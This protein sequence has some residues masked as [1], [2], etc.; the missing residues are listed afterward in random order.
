MRVFSVGIIAVLLL[1]TLAAGVI[2]ADTRMGG[3]VTVGPDE[4]VDDDLTVVGGTVVIEG[5]VTGDVTVIG[6]T[7]EIPGEV[8]GDVSIVGGSLQVAGV[9]AGDVS[10]AAGSVTI[11]QGAVIGSLAAGAGSVDIFGTVEG[12][13]DVGAGT[14][15]LGPTAHVHGDL[16]YAGGPRGGELRMDDAARVDG[17][18]TE[19]VVRGWFTVWPTDLFDWAAVFVFGLMHLLLGAIL[20]ILLPEFSTDLAMAVRDRPVRTAAI[21]AAILFGTPILLVMLL[22]T[23]VGIPLA[24]AGAMLLLI[25]YWIGLVY[26]RYAIGEWLL[27]A[28]DI[29]NRWIA[30]LV[31]LVVVGIIAQIPLL[32]WL[33][34]LVVTLVGIGALVDLAWARRSAGETAQA[35]A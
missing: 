12:D 18:V 34:S 16:T 28:T 5:T 7:T 30:L 6:G 4:T 21:G 32:G 14:I 9:I 27:S 24:L 15:T 2:V 20:L 19:E 8:Q 23:I 3:H 33:V 13:V 29:D 35:P 1:G 10:V 25:V 17:T 31:G 22:V 11:E 26:G